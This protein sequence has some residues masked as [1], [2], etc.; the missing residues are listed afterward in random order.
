M[1]GAICGYDTKDESVKLKFFRCSRINNHRFSGP[2]DEVE[3][4]I[5][6]FAA[7]RA[8][9]SGPSGSQGDLRKTRVL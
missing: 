4:I 3:L 1:V 5:V 6:S 7:V 2:E 8:R 9:K